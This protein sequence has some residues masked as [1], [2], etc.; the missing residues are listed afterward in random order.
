MRVIFAM[1]G[2]T[3]LN[4]NEIFYKAQ[5]ERTQIF[6]VSHSVE[7]VNSSSQ[8]DARFSWP[9]DNDFYHAEDIAYF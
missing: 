6:C 9:D 8:S 2:N 4:V 7:I 3:P 5:D 1:T